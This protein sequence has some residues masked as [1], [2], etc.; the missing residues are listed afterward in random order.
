[1]RRLKDRQ[2]EYKRSFIETK[3]INEWIKF[4]GREVNYPILTPLEIVVE[5]L[6]SLR[7]RGLTNYFTKFNGHYLFSLDVNM[8]EAFMEVYGKTREEMRDKSNTLKLK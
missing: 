6:I 3:G 2:E 1:M 7:K 4:S 8:D 5:S